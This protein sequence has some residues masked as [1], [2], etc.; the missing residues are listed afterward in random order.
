M[1]KSK[2]ELGEEC[3]RQIR[4]IKDTNQLLSGKWKSLIISHLYYEK[5]MRFMD[6]IRQL[7]EIAPK[8]L[9]KELKELELN[10]LIKRTVKD[11]MPITV[12]YELSESG[13]SLHS[14]IKVMSEWGIN[15]RERLYSTE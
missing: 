5:T 7:E 8:V 4:G 3:L 11:T 2:L 9:S 14:V 13:K 10:K 1:K 12:E 15:Y 6:L